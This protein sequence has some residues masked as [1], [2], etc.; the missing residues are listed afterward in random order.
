MFLSLIKLIFG[1]VDCGPAA[2]CR[3]PHLQ[4]AGA[5]RGRGVSCTRDGRAPTAQR[6][7][8]SCGVPAQAPRGTRNLPGPGT[9]AT[10]PALERGPLTSGQPGKS[11]SSFY[12]ASID[13][14]TMLLA[15]TEKCW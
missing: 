7:A 6:K 4:Q 2:A 11:P 1:W 9:E 12:R 14:I 15:Y 13:F 3:F 10:S 5:T 8:S